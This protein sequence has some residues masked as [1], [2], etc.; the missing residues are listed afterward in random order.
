[1]QK[2][3]HKTALSL[4]QS[5]VCRIRH[6]YYVDPTLAHTELPRPSHPKDLLISFRWLL[7]A[8]SVYEWLQPSYPEEIV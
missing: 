7:G 3:E 4:F 5:L 2:L 6:Y 1:M 8:F